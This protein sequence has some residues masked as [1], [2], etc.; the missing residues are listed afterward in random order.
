MVGLV[1]LFSRKGG[2]RVSFAVLLAPFNGVSIVDTR[3]VCLVKINKIRIEKGS[4]SIRNQKVSAFDFYGSI[5]EEGIDL[6][7]N[8]GEGMETFS[9][10]FFLF[11]LEFISFSDE[12]YWGSSIFSVL[13]KYNY[14]VAIY[15]SYREV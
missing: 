13:I 3:D 14:G 8:S 7:L 10:H 1:Y 4:F 2:K 9:F 15:N 5:S 6:G 11:D 12:K